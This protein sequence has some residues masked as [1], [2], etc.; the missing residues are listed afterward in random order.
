M[1]AEMDRD[2][3]KNVFHAADG[4]IVGRIRVQKIFYLLEQLGLNSGIRYSYHYYGPYSEELAKSLDYAEIID[5]TIFESQGTT[6]FGATFS[7]YESRIK[8][9]VDKV[10]EISFSEAATMISS[11]KSFPSVVIELAAT[12][13]WLVNKE[14]IANWRESLKIRKPNKAG[15]ENIA[16]AVRLLQRLNLASNI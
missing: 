1:G 10:G 13:H 14:G 12:I 11:M 4:K 3:I 9:D 15:D 6:S 16:Q 8:E 7:I 2:I 5:G